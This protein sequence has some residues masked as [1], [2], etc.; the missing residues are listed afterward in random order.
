MW[1]FM[2]FNPVTAESYHADGRT[3]MT[4]LTA[5]FAFCE[6]TKNDTQINDKQTVSE[7][8]IYEVPG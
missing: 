4:Y 7:N 5:T 2:K 3:D 8:K 6:T 1:N